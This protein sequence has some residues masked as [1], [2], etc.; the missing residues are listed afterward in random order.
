MI[1]IIIIISLETYH[2]AFQIFRYIHR[3]THI[4]I[5]TH[6]II[7]II[8]NHF[9]RVITWMVFKMYLITVHYLFEMTHMYAYLYFNHIIIQDNNNM[10]LPCVYVYVCTTCKYDR[11]W[12]ISIYLFVKIINNNRNSGKPHVHL[13]TYKIWIPTHIS[14]NNSHK[15]WKM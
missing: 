11:K 6:L 4:E 9:K 13:H 7:I 10:P 3:H 15:F 8:H 14:V 12:Q 5:N 1:I 2:A